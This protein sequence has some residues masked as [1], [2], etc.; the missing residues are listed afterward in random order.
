MVL[1]I[2]FSSLSKNNTERKHLFQIFNYNFTVFAVKKTQSKR[3]SPLLGREFESM[4]SVENMELIVSA[5]PLSL[6]NVKFGHSHSI[7]I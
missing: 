5:Y 1:T 7:N 6:I 3:F 2:G 4:K